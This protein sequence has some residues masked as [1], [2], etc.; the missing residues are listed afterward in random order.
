MYFV[1]TFYQMWRYRLLLQEHVRFRK[2][3]R[4]KYRQPERSS[5]QSHEAAIAEIRSF[6]RSYHLERHSFV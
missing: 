2:R 1:T 3:L 4:K 6:Q 5:E